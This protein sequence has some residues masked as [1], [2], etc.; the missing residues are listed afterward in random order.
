MSAWLMSDLSL[1]LLVV[2]I[3][4]VLISGTAV[5][6][7]VKGWQQY[8]ASFTAS[9]E[10]NLEKMFM[11][12]DAKKMF[13]GNV[14]MIIGVPA[15]VF[16]TTENMFYVLL[17]IL[18][19]LSMPTIM[20]K[21]LEAR[22]KQQIVEALPDALAQISGSMRSGATFTSSIETMVSETKG[23]IGQEFELL[24]KEQKMGISQQDSLENLGERISSEDVDLVVTAALIS[25]DVGG[26]LAEILGRL[27]VTLRRKIEMEG[28]IKALT[29]QG[30]LQGIVV[31]MLPFAIIFAL[32]YVE[33]EGI[34][35]IFSTF[36]GWGFLAA[37]VLLE[38]MGAIMI[39]KIVSIDV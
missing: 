13:L 36:L 3:G 24:L 30:K 4:V 22:R 10:S 11:F 5:M 34:M 23:P 32:V 28:K 1:V 7:G 2:F 16:I 37:I 25:R 39:R 14:A 38:I 6:L 26:N 12:V 21:V 18:I 33:P 15:L 8:Q 27:S 19:V 9:T 20:M 35:P 31:S 17:S 29:S